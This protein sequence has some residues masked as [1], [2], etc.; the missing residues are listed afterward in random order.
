MA[1]S[2]ISAS[3]TNLDTSMV[4]DFSNRSAICPAVADSST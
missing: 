3:S 4:R 1:A 2:T